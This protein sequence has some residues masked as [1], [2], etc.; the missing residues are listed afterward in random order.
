M[1]TLRN[2][3]A[4]VVFALLAITPAAAQT[5]YVPHMSVGV[6]GGVDMSNIAF[7]PKVKQSMLMGANFGFAFTYAEERHVGLRAELNLAQRGWKENFEEHNDAFSYSRTINYITLPVMTHI[8]FGGRHVKCL[9]NLGPEF[10]FM[11]SDSRKANFDYNDP[12]SVPDFPL[13]N[14]YV[15]QMGMK[16]KNRFDYGI[17]AGIGVEFLINRWHSIQIEARYYFGLGNIYSAT[18]RDEFGASRNNTISASVGYF[19]RFK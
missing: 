18:K 9:F 3:L 8:F 12:Q 1:K 16:I 14:R 11:L 19:F 10:G 7:S 4:I 17:T 13:Q 6:R 2:I 5:H 15:D